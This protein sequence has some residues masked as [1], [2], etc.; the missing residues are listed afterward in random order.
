MKLV[1]VPCMKRKLE[2]IYDK[3]IK[4]N[5][6]LMYNNLEFKNYT[7]ITYKIILSLL[8]EYNINVNI[9]SPI[10][11]YL[12][13]NLNSFLV[14]LI[15]SIKSLF[16]KD[17]YIILCGYNEEF[18]NLDK[19]KNLSFIYS[20]YPKINNL[21]D[22]LYLLDKSRC[23]E[24]FTALSDTQSIYINPDSSCTI[25]TSILKNQPEFTLASTNHIC[26]VDIIE[27]IDANYY[28]DLYL[29]GLTNDNFNH[30]L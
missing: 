25:S 3:S 18:I 11:L 6:Y 28:F 5:L 15:S 7:N 30:Y 14:D 2:V 10:Y 1:S 21:I 17:I 22:D 12:P 24:V 19:Y 27:N 8:D 26:F 4:G 29:K 20:K 23:Y 9:N 16:N 13:F